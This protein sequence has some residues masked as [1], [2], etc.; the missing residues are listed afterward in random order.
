V[1]G[2][3][4]LRAMAAVLARARRW[5][6]GLEEFWLENGRWLSARAGVLV[7]RVL[8]AKERRGL[9][10][11]ICDGGRTLHALVASW[12]QHDL[13]SLPARRGAA[14]L[15]AVTGPTCMAFDQLARRRLPRSLRPGD[16]LV[17]LDAG[18]YHLPWET[19]FSHGLA[20]VAWHD[21][22]RVR[23]VREREPFENWWGQWR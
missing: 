16:H 2:K 14:V 11:L 6:P 17:W 10:H 1:A 15:T 8:D 5:F 21:G 20:A 12:E 13:F 19:R 9:R 18:A 22:R 3:F 7:V 23:I 4:E